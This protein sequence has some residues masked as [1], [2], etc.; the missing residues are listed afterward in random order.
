MGAQKIEQNAKGRLERQKIEDEANAE[1]QRA[2]LLKLQ[3]ETQAIET[4]GQATAEAQARANAAGI[5][6]KASVEMAKL[7]AEALKIESDS[8]L[9]QLKAKQAQEIA[10]ITALDRLEVDKSKKLAEIEAEKFEETIEAIG[11]DTI[12][13]IAKAGPETQAKLLQG[14]GLKGFLVTDG[15]S[16]INLFNTANGLVGG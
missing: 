2:D 7:K 9:Q 14:L 6:G 3:A 11:R 8:Q 10:H 13:Q 5:E 12:T 4:K 16:P 1:R 15:N